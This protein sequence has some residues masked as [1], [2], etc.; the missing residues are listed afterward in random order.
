VA[1]TIKEMQLARQKTESE[2]PDSGDFF[3]MPS[4]E[5]L[6]KQ[7]ARAAA[8]ALELHVRGQNVWVS[9]P[10]K[11]V[12]YDWNTG[13]QLQEIPLLSGLS[14][15]IPLGDEFLLLAQNDVGQEVI[16]H[17]NLATGKTREEEIGEPTKA[18]LASAPA[19][20]P[21]SGAG[22]SSRAGA[23]AGATPPSGSPKPLDPAK[24]ASQVQR[25]PLPGRIALPAV[26]AVSA[27]Q[28]KVL[29]EIREQERG[30]PRPAPGLEAEPNHFSLIPT[31]DGFVQFSVNLLESKIVAHSAMKARPK[32]SALDGPVSV[33]ATADVANEI[34]NEMQR[35]RAGDM[36]E[37]DESRYQVTVRL[38]GAK[39][40]PDWTGE[41]VGPP[42]LYPLKTV[43]VIAAGKTLTVLDKSNKKKWQAT[44]NYRVAEGAGAL[45]EDHAPY[46]LGPCV[47]RGDTLYVIDQGVLTAFD[48]EKGEARWRL[49]SVGIAGL[50][51][52]DEGKIYLNSTTASPDAIKYSRQIDVSEKTSA[53]ILKLDPQKGT[54]LWAAEPGGQISHLSGKFIYTIQ[55]YQPDDDEDNPYT[56]DTGFEKLPYMKIKRINPK[57]GRVMW[58]HFQ[59]RA[60]LNVQFEKNSIQL[61]FKKEVQVLKFL[62]F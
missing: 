34:F 52:D 46:G 25:M 21:K 28:E 42:A 22:K 20:P 27:N 10:E 37:E 26:L 49:P 36:V 54:T 55:S 12:R 61:V 48:L 11:L 29:A 19:Q 13:K 24:V 31:R 53:V 44:L 6:A 56:P 45:D 7:M 9:T 40:V 33:T 50:F 51:F 60:P 3:K 58:E 15:A 32:K 14:G 43:N 41:V 5:K 4:P 17:I 18:A 39:D 62:S 8:E 2:N 57:T 38:P 16:T 59:Q 1:A 47:E 30:K 23:I 35:D